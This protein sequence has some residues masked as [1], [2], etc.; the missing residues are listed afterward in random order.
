LSSTI[1]KRL[2]GMIFFLLENFG[3]KAFA[4]TY[5][6]LLWSFYHLLGPGK[7]NAAGRNDEAPD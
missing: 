1:N 4:A 6:K 7:K 2:L 5:R 3:A